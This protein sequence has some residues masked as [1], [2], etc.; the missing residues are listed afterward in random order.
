MPFPKMTKAKKIAA[1]RKAIKNRKTP[2]Q[3]L[4]SMRTRLAKLE[5]GK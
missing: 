4:P 1:L 3:F 5:R 2:K